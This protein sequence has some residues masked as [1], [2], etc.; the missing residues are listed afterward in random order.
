[1]LTATLF[2]IQCNPIT[3]ELFAAAIAH[4][5]QHPGDEGQR[6]IAIVHLH[7]DVQHDS[8]IVDAATTMGVSTLDIVAELVDMWQAEIKA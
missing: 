6:A 1:M 2:D 8:A 7:E 5:R 4:I 3:A